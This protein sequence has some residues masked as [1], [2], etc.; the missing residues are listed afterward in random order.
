MLKLTLT[1]ALF[2]L[3]SFAMLSWLG[4]F[5]Q[6]ERRPDSDQRPNIVL[7]SIDTLRADHLEAYGYDRETSPTMAAMASQGILFKR[8]I[9]PGSLDT[10]QCRFFAYVIISIRT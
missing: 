7:I 9:G 3:L 6:H 2:G 10:S 5:P 4:I 8:A 1:I